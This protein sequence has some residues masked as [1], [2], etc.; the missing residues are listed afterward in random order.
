[1][2]NG[3]PK[4]L[5]DGWTLFRGFGGLSLAN[6]GEIGRKLKRPISLF[7][8]TRRRRVLT[9]WCWYGTSLI[10]FVTLIFVSF[11]RKSRTPHDRVVSRWIQTT[12][13][14]PTSCSGYSGAPFCDNNLHNPY[15]H[16]ECLLSLSVPIEVLLFCFPSEAMARVET[17]PLSTDKSD[18]KRHRL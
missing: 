16:D 18:I 17:T 6:W 13:P 4:W 11:F 9:N 2:E 14:E 15:Q 8:Q 10:L 1:M 7:D 3:P 5:L 12:S